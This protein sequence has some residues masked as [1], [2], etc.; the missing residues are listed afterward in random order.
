MVTGTH[1]RNAMPTSP[2]RASL[3]LIGLIGSGG[4]AWAAPALELE[5]EL[6]SCVRGSPPLALPASAERAVLDGADRRH[7]EQAA[8]A[9]Y[10]LYQQGGL[11]STQVLLLRRG[12]H[13]QYATLA[14]DGSRL[15]LSAVFAADRFSFTPAWLGKYQPRAAEAAD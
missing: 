9:R 1:R 3:G 5:L 12:R 4:A 15:C 8:Q 10:P 6:P 11:V 14:H 2:R 13:W 7:F